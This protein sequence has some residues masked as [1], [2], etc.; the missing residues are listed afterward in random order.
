MDRGA[1]WAT[2]QGVR[3]IW[4]QLKRLSRHPRE[5][6]PYVENIIINLETAEVKG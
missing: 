2:V 1:W 4:T 3:K 5:S 6:L